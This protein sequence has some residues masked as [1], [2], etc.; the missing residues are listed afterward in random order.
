MMKRFVVIAVLVLYCTP[1]SAETLHVPCAEY[2]TIQSAVDDAN[3]GDIIIVSAGLYMENL[4]FLGKAITVR[5]A[6]PNDP[7]IVAAT[8]IDGSNPA[9]PNIGSVVT[10]KNG[11]GGDCVLS[12]FTIQNGTGQSDP[13]GA[14]WYWKGP[15]GGG[16]FC[17][18]ASPAI[19]GNVFRR[20]RAEYGGGAI[21]CHDGASPAIIN[22][23]FIDNY[24]GAYGGAVFARLYC[25]PTIS[26]NTFE[27]NQCQVLGGA[28]YLADHCHS[29]I[30]NNWFERNDCEI[31]HGGAIYYMVSCSP[32]VAC[33]F[34]VGNT[35]SG[36]DGNWA[37][38]AAILAEGYTSGKIINNLF[39][40]NACPNNTRGVVI[41]VGNYANESI[42]NNI[43]YVNGDIA[44]SA[45]SGATPAIFNNNVWANTGGN[46]HDSIGDQTGI[47]GNISADPMV[48]IALPEPFTCYES[49]PNS[50]CIDAGGNGHLPAWLVSDYDGTSRVVNGTVDIGPQEYDAIAVPQDFNTIQE[51]INAA[52]SGDE[53]IVSPGFYRE[54]V[55]FLDK[56]IMLRSINPLDANC[57]AETIIDGNESDSC[58]KILSGQ[59][60]STAVAGLRLQNGRGEFGGGIYIDNG[61]GPVIMCNFITSNYAHRYGGGIDS[62]HDCRSKI[63][64]NTIIDNYANDC[65]GGIHNGAYSACL[66]QDNK[67]VSNSARLNGGAIYSFNYSDIRI[68]NNEIVRNTASGGGGVYQWDGGG[69]VEGNK[70]I[71]NAVTN[72]GGGISMLASRTLISNNLVCANRARE[73]AGILIWSGGSCKV[74][75]NTV[76]ANVSDEAGAGITVAYNVHCPIMNNII[77]SNGSGGGLYVK[78]HFLA[79]EPNVTANDLWDN[80]DGNYLG[81]TNDL[82]GVYGNISVDPCFIDPG[83]WTDNNT[84]DTNDDYWVQGYYRIPYYSPCR[85]AGTSHNAPE[86][87]YE[88]GPRPQFS[89]FDIGAY[90]LQVYDLTGTGTVDFTE[91][92]LLADSWLN[93]GVSMPADLNFDGLVDARDF[94]LFAVGWLL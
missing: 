37:T 44:I 24:A 82:T 77:S 64:C 38:G 67:I 78:P 90:E 49:H 69:I 76:V 66:I 87:D 34:F 11:E 3:S 84:P 42:A 28:V 79:S 61:A 16:V 33:N 51:A 18:G 63:I 47:N 35:C 53:I 71:E 57:V 14:S 27:K 43:I 10:F 68:L 25:S 83:Y 5:S 46:Y 23:T 74:I 15:N 17:R 75:N 32:I 19:T 1:L 56:N 41:K 60:Q 21:Y 94:A 7:N 12:G 72:T 89:G 73:G 39:T 80:Q 2:G 22:N 70:F 48:G 29:K 62:R 85:D 50:P 9:D 65:G 58:I 54:N 8:I 45:G 6:D 55:N 30:T 88:G 52:Q 13:C 4:D 59:N 91:I 20:C 92:G 26:E 81:D 31:L 40:E 36:P 86:T 93:E